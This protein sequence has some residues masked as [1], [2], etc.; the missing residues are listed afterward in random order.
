MIANME[1]TVCFFKDIYGC[2]EGKLSKSK[3]V[4]TVSEAS[5][6][7]ND[8]LAANLPAPSDEATITCHKNCISRYVSPSSLASVKKHEHPHTSVSDCETKKLRSEGGVDFNFKAHCFF[9]LEVTQCSVELER[10]LPLK[11][12]KA[13]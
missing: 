11:Y 4:Q 1:D 2:S 3:R 9:C 7:R 13:I 10:K 12:R 5:Q 6:L 8:G